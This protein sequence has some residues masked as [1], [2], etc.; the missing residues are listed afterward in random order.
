[1]A[2]KLYVVT[3]SDLVPGQ[4]A[5]QAMHALREFVAEHPETDLAWYKSSNH[6][7]LLSVRDERSLAHL[8]DKASRRGILVSLFREPDR[9]N[10]LTAIALEPKGRQLCRNLPLALG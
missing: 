5:V 9:N 8:V 10:E 1:M 6:L 7:A 2:E 4:Q 3:R